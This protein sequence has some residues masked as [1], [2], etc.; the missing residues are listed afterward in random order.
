MQNSDNC[1]LKDQC[2]V[3]VFTSNHENLKCDPFKMFKY[4]SLL[5]FKLSYR[6]EYCL[7]GCRKFHA[8]KNEDDITS[9][10]WGVLRK[11]PYGHPC[12]TA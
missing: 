11:P 3:K 6:Y 5:I 10:D 4:N 9:Y 7:E 8:E 2:K 1:K 12:Q